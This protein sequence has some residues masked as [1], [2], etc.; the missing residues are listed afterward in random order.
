[1]TSVYLGADH[2]GFNLKEKI[3]LWLEEWHYEVH[4]V[5]NTTYDFD[6]DWSD[7]A[8]RVGEAVVNHNGSR[9]ILVCSSGVGVCVAAN[10]VK[11][12]R[13]A[14]CTNEKQARFSRNDDDVNILCLSSELVDDDTNRQ[15]IK[16]FLETIFGGEERY[17]RRIRKVKDYEIGKYQPPSPPKSLKIDTLTR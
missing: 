14:L 3:K 4:D 2:R 6:D 15:I 7:F 16:T 13:A 11:G 9:G 8:I 10:K 17:I 5:G 1:M 12:V